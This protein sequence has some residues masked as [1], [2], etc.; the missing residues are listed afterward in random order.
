MADDDKFGSDTLEQLTGHPRV[1][2]DPDVCEGCPE[3]GGG[4]MKKCGLCGCPTIS[5]MPMDMLDA[6]PSD[7]LRI[8]QHKD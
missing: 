4:V 7:C 6:P 8:D 2:F 3:R 5:N 1:G